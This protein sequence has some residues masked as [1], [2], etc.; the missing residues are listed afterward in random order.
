MTKK[1]VSVAKLARLLDLNNF[2]EQ[3]NLKQKRYVLPRSTALRCSCMAI[4]SILQR[5]AYRLSEW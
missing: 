1:E 3:V 5:G 2:T 4:L